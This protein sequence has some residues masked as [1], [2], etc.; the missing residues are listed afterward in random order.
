MATRRL[1]LAGS[2]GLVAALLA[3]CERKPTKADLLKKAETARTRADLEKALGNP[4]EIDKVGPAQRWTY[5]ASDG[6]VTFMIMADRVVLDV[7][8]GKPK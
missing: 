3:G 7:T 4:D 2:A 6:T 5:K 1:L 8:G